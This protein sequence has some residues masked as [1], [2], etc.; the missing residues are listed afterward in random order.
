MATK[1]IPCVY[2]HSGIL[3]SEEKGGHSP[4]VILWTDLGYIMLKEISQIDKHCKISLIFGIL[5][6]KK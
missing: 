5:K 4:F 3:F 1:Y 2:L 6:K